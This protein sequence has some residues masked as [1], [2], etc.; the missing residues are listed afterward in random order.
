[1][2]DRDNLKA[3]EEQLKIEQQQF[4]VSANKVKQSSDKLAPERERVEIEQQK[5]EE[6]KNEP[7]VWFFD[8]IYLENMYEM[9]NRINS[10]ER[11]VGWY[12]SGPKIK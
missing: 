7:D 10:R 8:H 12:S 1:M 2:Q 9:Q 5:F 4:E 6:E 11:I 3:K